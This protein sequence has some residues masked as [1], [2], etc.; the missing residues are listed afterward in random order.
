MVAVGIDIGT[1]N[2]GLIAID[3][4]EGIVVERFSAPNARV[5]SDNGYAYLQDPVRIGDTVEEL[6]EHLAMNAASIGITGR[7]R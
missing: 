7:K 4:V 6:F 5:P 3:L 1:T 2:I